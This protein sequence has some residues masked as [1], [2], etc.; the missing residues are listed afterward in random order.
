MVEKEPKTYCYL[1][2][3]GKKCVKATVA[4]K[5]LPYYECDKCIWRIRS[6]DPRHLDSLRKI[7]EK[8]GIRRWT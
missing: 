5:H 7:Y 3:N 2:R 6:E 8:Y 1:I 4:K